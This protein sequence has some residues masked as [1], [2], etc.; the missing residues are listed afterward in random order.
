MLPGHVAA[1]ARQQRR[2]GAHRVQARAQTLQA[3]V[4]LRFGPRRDV[5]APLAQRGE[6]KGPRQAQRVESIEQVQPEAALGNHVV[7]RLLR[8]GDHPHIDGDVRP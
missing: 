3:A 6:R 8:G 5:F 1:Q 4:D 2:K 7:Q